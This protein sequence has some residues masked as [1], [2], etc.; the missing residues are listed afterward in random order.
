MRKIKAA[1][2]VQDLG[3]YPRCAVDKGHV[4]TL[5][6]VLE[7]GAV[8]P[9]LV[10]CGKTRKLIDGFHRLNAYTQRHGDEH[11]VDVLEKEYATP[12]EMWLDAVRYNGTIHDFVLLNALRN[13]PSTVAAIEQVSEGIRSHLGE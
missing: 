5:V 4:Q 2:I 8:L 3:I 1:E 10:I 7:A 9:P 11:E 12:R 6:L 13:V